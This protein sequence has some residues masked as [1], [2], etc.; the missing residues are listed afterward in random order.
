MT[1]MRHIVLDW[2]ERG[3][4]AAPDVPRALVVAGVLPSR[5]SWR[6]FID[7]LLLWMGTVLV[8]G[9]LIFFLAYNWQDLGRYAKFGLVEALVVVALVFIWRLG[10]DRPSG[11][12]VLL[13][14]CLLFG[15]L[16]ALIGQTY[17]TGAD[18]FELFGAWAAMILPWVLVGRSSVLWLLWL[19]LDNLAIGF[20]FQA[21]PTIFGLLFD[22][23]QVLWVLFAVNTAALAVGEAAAARGIEWLRPR[24]T[25]RLI[26]SASS[27][28]ATGLVIIQIL[29]PHEVSAWAVV[30]WLAW[31]GAVWAVYRRPVK[32]VFVLACGVLSVIV[33]VATFF[34]KHLSH[35]EAIGFLLVGLIVIGLS[36]AGG[37]W[38]K[39]MATED[40]Q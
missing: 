6:R 15:A 18:T 38:L 32:D 17:Q 7:Q 35:H 27:G 22:T 24:W 12:A 2:A 28:F 10:L 19:A 26:A 25:L 16:L 37:W 4:I 40:E 39:N 29:E 33:V 13:G 3:R 14:T 34:A 31:L 5:D 1:N 36:A 9:G 20:Y 11:K 21:V 23:E 8:A 30:A